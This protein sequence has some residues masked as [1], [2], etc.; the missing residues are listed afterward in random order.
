MSELA[1][2]WRQWIVIWALVCVQ[3]G[4]SL[5]LSVPGC[6]TGYL[7]PGGAAHHSAPPNCTGGA[8]RY[9]D[10]LVFG[11]HHLYHRS[12]VS[13]VYHTSVPFDPEGTFF[14]FLKK[15]VASILMCHLCQILEI[16]Y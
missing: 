16:Y 6:P 12:R 11:D 13:K 5:H 10:S 3:V 14:Q 7:G 15:K 8:A 1:D 9:I 4:V 2:S